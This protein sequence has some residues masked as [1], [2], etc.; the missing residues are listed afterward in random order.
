M[1]CSQNSVRSFQSQPSLPHM[2]VTFDPDVSVRVSPGPSQTDATI[3]TYFSNCLTGF[4]QDGH[5]IVPFSMDS[6]IRCNDIFSSR[7]R[8][9]PSKP[10]SARSGLGHFTR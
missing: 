3:S 9:N 5:F 4:L 8:M 2:R 10:L 1:N 7:L 6:L